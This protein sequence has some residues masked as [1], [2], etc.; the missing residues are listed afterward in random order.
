MIRFT[1]LF[2]FLA[3]LIFFIQPAVAQDTI[4]SRLVWKVNKVDLGTILEEQGEQMAVFEFTHSLDSGVWI[5]RVWTDC[6]C[7]TADYSKDTIS[8]GESGHLQVSFDPSSAVGDFSRMVVVK[9][10]LAGMQD[11]LFIEGKSIPFPTDPEVDYPV[12]RGQIGLRMEKI[13][14]GDVF[15]N[16]PSS[17]TVEIYNFSDSTLYRDSLNYFGPAHIQVQQ[18]QDS[19]E[20][21]NRGLLEI[22]YSGAEKNDLGFFED[23]IQLTWPDSLVA[24]ADVIANVFEFY[25]SLSK[26]QLGLVP[27]L[28]ISPSEIDLK[29]IS[30]DEIQE[31]FYTFTNR[32]RELL[33]IKKVQ[34]N[35]ECLELTLPK[36]ELAPGE[37]MDLKVVFDPKGR[38]GIDQRN[39]YI[40]SNDPLN[41]IQSVILKSR[42]K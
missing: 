28:R 10:N 6:G 34:G 25:P 20:S 37:S 32:G 21:K 8:A 7:T 18:L 2:I 11:T 41:S 38:K 15:T 29:E 9:G 39:I 12:V 16:E 14:M 13:N 5:E 33:E 24:D 27:T 31:V 22:T 3:N 19:I 1:V 42:I 40:F 26:D 30:E 36:L 23:P 17:R 4:P 35:C